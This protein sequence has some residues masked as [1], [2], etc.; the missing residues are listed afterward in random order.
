MRFAVEAW[1]PEYGSAMGVEDEL[2]AST[3]QVD[4]DVEV[5]LAE[6]APRS[7]PPGAADAVRSVVFSDGVRRVEAQVWVEV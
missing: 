1:A 2:A 7:P 4:H 6:W 3:A 5:P